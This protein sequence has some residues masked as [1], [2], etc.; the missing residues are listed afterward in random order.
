MRTKLKALLISAIATIGLAIPI[1]M[2]APAATADPCTGTWSIGMAGLGDNASMDFWGKVDQ[3]VGYNTNNPITGLWE[4]DRLFWSH[5]DQCPGDHIKLIGHSEGAGLVHVWVT[6][7]QW[8]GNANAILLSDP[9]RF[10]PGLGEPGMA[11]LSGPF[12]FAAPWFPGFLT[13]PL[14][15]VDDWFGEFPVLSICRW[16]DW[17][18]NTAAFPGYSHVTGLHGAYNFWADAYGDWDSGPWMI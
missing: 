4:L 3:P 14:A 17:V 12:G 13:Y 1:T 16:D 2:Q 7:H 11:N 9:K 15:G 6:E 10:Y 5:R 8:V 18:C